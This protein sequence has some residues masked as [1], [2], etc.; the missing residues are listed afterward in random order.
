[1]R[2]RGLRAAEL[3]RLDRYRNAFPDEPV[4][5]GVLA[6][7]R[8][9][10]ANQDVAAWQEAFTADD[11]TAGRLVSLTHDE[12]VALRIV[13]MWAS[14]RTVKWQRAF[15]RKRR[16]QKER[17]RKAAKRAAEQAR[18]ERRQA[19]AALDDRRAAVVALLDNVHWVTVTMLALDLQDHAAFRKQKGTG[20]GR[21]LGKA[22]LRTELHRIVRSLHNDRWIDTER[23]PT[24]RGLTTL[25]LRRRASQIPEC[26]REIATVAP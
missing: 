12:R 7:R 8:A 4:K 3:L 1:M 14:D 10:S 26:G 17:A 24:G 19:A 13:T 23:R 20:H 22:A 15:A 11:E 5:F 2:P 9:R 25:F 18:F 21:R 6:A 16:R